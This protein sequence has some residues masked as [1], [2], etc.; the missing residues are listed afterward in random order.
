MFPSW[1]GWAAQL[2]ETMKDIT[3]QAA[4]TVV[5]LTDKGTEAFR[6]MGI[7]ETI[8][9]IMEAGQSAPSEEPHQLQTK[10]AVF[11]SMKVEVTPAHLPPGWKNTAAEWELLIRAAWCCRSC[12]VIPPSVYI[13]DKAMWQD[14]TA[15]LHLS[16]EDAEKLVKGSEAVYWAPPDTIAWI[17]S[18]TD[19]HQMY[20][21][22]VPLV[23]SDEGYLQNI[24]WRIELCRYTVNA[25][26]LLNLLQLVSL[27]PLEVGVGPAGGAEANSD[28]LASH[29]R[30][31]HAGKVDGYWARTEEA[32]TAIHESIAWQDTLQTE[33]RT[34]LT[35]ALSNLNVLR[36]LTKQDSN[37]ALAESVYESCEYHKI[38]LSKL[39]GEVQQHQDRLAA[40]PLCQHTGDLYKKLLDVY[41]DVSAAMIT[42]HD[43]V[44]ATRSG[45]EASQTLSRLFATPD[46]KLES[47]KSPTSTT[48]G[49]VD[50]DVAERQHGE[51]SDD[52]DT[53]FEARLPWDESGF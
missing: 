38:K 19:V 13:S 33:V 35:N 24:G 36:G 10:A 53:V 29:A 34:E 43:S 50:M 6:Q 2:S 5:T 8:D 40:T 46:G 1:S 22:V 4:D 23:V 37:A 44:R 32:W 9:Q 26:Q 42:F 45:R 21:D 20:S 18:N 3:E 41:S 16:E 17:S 39:I 47:A 15:L 7:L 14:I 27:E 48:A 30:W 51:D 49:A 31:G 28:D 52:D 25:P 12:C 11:V